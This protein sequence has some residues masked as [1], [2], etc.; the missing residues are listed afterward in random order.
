[1]DSGIVLAAGRV[2][3]FRFFVLLTLTVVVALIIVLV[4]LKMKRKR[5]RGQPGSPADSGGYSCDG[6]A[7]DRRSE[8]PSPRVLA[9]DHSA[10]A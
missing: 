10:W 2:P 4:W 7:V 8:D 3:Y 5:K 1:M 9:T 6:K